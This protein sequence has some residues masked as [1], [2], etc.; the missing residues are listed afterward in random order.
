MSSTCAPTTGSLNLAQW[1]RSYAAMQA[2]TLHKRGAQISVGDGHTTR[3]R[4]ILRQPR[5]LYTPFHALQRCRC[6]RSMHAWRDMAFLVVVEMERFE[7]AFCRRGTEPKRGPGCAGVR[8]CAQLSP[9]L[10]RNERPSAY[11]AALPPCRRVREQGEHNQLCRCMRRVSAGERRVR[12]GSLANCEQGRR[13][14][15]R[16]GILCM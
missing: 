9:R 12:V 7:P 15:T 4:G 1:G 14:R 11:P 16:L 3:R 8:A 13:D 6:T 10:H 2:C 5:R